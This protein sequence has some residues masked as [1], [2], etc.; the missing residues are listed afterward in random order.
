MERLCKHFLHMER[1]NLN[2]ACVDRRSRDQGYISLRLTL[3]SEPILRY[4]WSQSAPYN[5]IN[6]IENFQFAFDTR[7]VSM[8]KTISHPRAR[9]QPNLNPIRTAI[10]AQCKTIEQQKH[11]EWKRNYL[12]CVFKDYQQT[13]IKMPNP[14]IGFYPHIK[15][16]VRLKRLI[17]RYI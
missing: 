11:T 10:S 2:D 9:F 14:P 12:H 7:R 6:I 4:L 16:R 15:R 3:S 8:R 1:E 17:K 5:T 13:N